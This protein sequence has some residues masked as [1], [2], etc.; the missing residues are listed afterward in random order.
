[1]GSLG[2]LKIC[3][4]VRTGSSPVPCTK[5]KQSKYIMTQNKMLQLVTDRSFIVGSIDENGKLSFSA[6]PVPHPDAT[7]A[8]AECRRLV[9]KEP[10]KAF[11]AVRFCGGAMVS[12]M[13]IL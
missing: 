10:G 1:M 2:R 13:T 9:A 3:C 8:I 5:T 12:G 7:Q 11:I 4:L 6:H